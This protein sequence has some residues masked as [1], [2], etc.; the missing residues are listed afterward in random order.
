M[1]EEKWRGRSGEATREVTCGPRAAKPGS[2]SSLADLAADM[3]D[4]EELLSKATRPR[5][6]ALVTEYLSQLREEYITRTGSRSSAPPSQ[7]AAQSSSTSSV[8]DPKIPAHDLLF[9][10][11]TSQGDTADATQAQPGASPDPP[12]S[13][14][15]PAPAPAQI[16]RAPAAPPPKPVRIENPPAPSGASEKTYST[17]PSF[18]WDQDSYGTEP[19]YVYVYLMSGLDGV[20]DVKDQVSCDFTPTSFDLK[21]HGYK[22]KNLRLLRNNLDKDIVPAESKV[23]HSLRRV[24]VSVRSGRGCV[25]NL[26]ARAVLLSLVRACRRGR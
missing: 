12:V 7:T 4:A 2:M 21:I 11:V 13:T 25:L 15:T 6:R 26:R 3:A 17:I 22:G 19:S 9:K 14:P 23:P 20:G 5:V 18:G 10:P 24:L 16:P 1:R 8:A